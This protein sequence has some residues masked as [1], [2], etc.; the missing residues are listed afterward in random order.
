MAARS[1]AQKL[2]KRRGRPKA[3]GA[4]EPNGRLSRS[5]IDH[6]AADSVAI[7]ARVRMLGITKDQAMD[8][9]AGSYIG[10]LNMLG[11]RDG[12]SEAQYEAAM[13]YLRLRERMLRAIQSQA[14]IYDPEAR[15]SGSAEISEAY[16]NWCRTTL[17][18][19]ETLKNEIQ[20]EQN[21]CR[22]NLWAALHLVIIEGQAMHHMIGETRLLCNVFARHFKT[23]TESRHA[24]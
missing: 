19:W 4:R 1:K 6:E 7:S 10:Y 11:P 24:A 20:A 17:E 18:E 5:G 8:Q 23:V 13:E 2:K 14:A 9:K 15:G 21:Y 16:E 3:E 12:I 22:G